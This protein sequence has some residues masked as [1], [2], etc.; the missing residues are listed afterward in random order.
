[1]SQALRSLIPSEDLPYAITTV[2]VGMFGLSA[3]SS[4][5]RKPRLRKKCPYRLIM[6][7]DLWPSFRLH[8]IRQHTIKLLGLMHHDTRHLSIS[9]LSHDLYLP[10]TVATP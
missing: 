1:M 4:K 2:L 7:L 5:L 3:P 8:G 10:S 9:G 6:A